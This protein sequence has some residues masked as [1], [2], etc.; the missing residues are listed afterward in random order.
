MSSNQEWSTLQFFSPL[1]PQHV[2]DKAIYFCCDAVLFK[3]VMEKWHYNDLSVRYDFSLSQFLYLDEIKI[4]DIMYSM[5]FSDI[6][7]VGKV[8]ICCLFDLDNLNHVPRTA[9]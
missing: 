6:H 8:R 1:T 9:S 7:V 2:C 3:A 4:D 5:A